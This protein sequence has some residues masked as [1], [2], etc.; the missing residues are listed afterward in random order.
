MRQIVRA[1][2]PLGEGVILD[3]FMGGGSTIAAAAAV[4]YQSIGIES[5]PEFFAMAKA[6]VP[7]LAAFVPNGDGNAQLAGNGK[8]ATHDQQSLFV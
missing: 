7:R 2:L 3:P 1:S 6:A 5:D 4:G 8:T